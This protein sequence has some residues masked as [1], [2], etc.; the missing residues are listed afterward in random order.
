MRRSILTLSFFVIALTVFCQSKNEATEFNLGFEK[1]TVKKKLPDNWFLWGSGYNIGMDTVVK[2]EGKTAVAISPDEKRDSGSFGCIAYKIPADFEAEEIEVSAYMK[3]ED[4]KDGSIGLMLRID[5]AAGTL[6]F[7]NMQQKNIRGTSGWSRYTVKL[8]YP[9]GAKTIVIGALLSGTGKLW[10]DNFELL[11]DGNDISV[12]KRKIKIIYKAENDTAFDQGSGIDPGMVTVARTG[13]LKMLGMIWGF[14]K[15]YHPAIAKGDYNWDYELFRVM[16]K[17]LRSAN[18]KERD[19]LL[20]GWIKSLGPIEVT[21]KTEKEEG[22]AIIVPDLEWFSNSDL[23]RELTDLLVNVKNAQRNEEN[24]YV[25][26]AEYVGN[27]VFKNENAYP[28]MN[29]PDVGFRLLSLYRYWNNIQYFFPYKNLIEEDWKGVLQEFIPEFV[30]AA[31]ETDYKLAVLK[32]IA[33]VHDTHA[34][35]WGQDEAITKFKGVNYAP[36]EMNFIG[37][38]AVVVGYYDQ[39]LGEKSG[40][41]VGDVIT[42]INNV[43]VKKIIQDKL[44]FTPASNYPKQL[45]MIAAGLLRTNDTIVDVEFSRNGTSSL[46]RVDT[47]P[48]SKINP[49]IDRHGSD[50]CFKLLSPEIA[51]IYPGT[52]KSDYLPEIMGKV[53]PAKGLI[54]DLRCYPS[55]F[56]VFSLGKYLVADST[57]FVKFTIGSI[58]SPGSFT[59]TPVLYVGEKNTDYYKGKVVIL[60]NETSVSQSEYTTMAFRTAPGATVVGSTTAGADGNVSFFKLPGGILTAISGIGVFYPDGKGTQRVGIVPDIEVKP[61]IQGILEGRDEL[62]EKAIKIIHEE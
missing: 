56:I 17:I 51:Y 38:Q 39:E 41:K 57:A 31:T 14:L 19:A 4:V 22:K 37:K 7:D 24:Y 32:L 8:P 36:V 35:I 43:P 61:T 54:I 29:Y 49:Y 21:G 18:A 33:R 11:L 9:G 20:V 48:S 34:N 60:V 59:M 47:Y 23:A 46:K 53:Q 5:G 15:Y 1:T 50:T 16:P 30:Q 10:V 44:K 25:G 62:I 40:L 12:A 52:I 58:T 6:Q 3:L 13:D 45:G 2:Y 42:A 27:P 28:D 26:M 55:D